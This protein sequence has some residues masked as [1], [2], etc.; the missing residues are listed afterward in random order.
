M[1]KLRFVFVGAAVFLLI[2]SAILPANAAVLKNFT[3][4]VTASNNNEFKITSDYGVNLTYDWG[5]QHLPAQRGGITTFRGIDITNLGSVGDTYDITASSSNED[6][7]CLALYRTG[8]DDAIFSDPLPITIAP[9]ETRS[10]EVRCMIKMDVVDIPTG[11]LPIVVEAH[12][13][14]DTNVGDSL[15]VYMNIIDIDDF[16][17]EFKMGKTEYT[18]KKNAP[19]IF[20]TF[21]FKNVGNEM[22]GLTGPCYTTYNDR[23]EPTLSRYCCMCW[24]DLIPNIPVSWWGMLIS[25]PGTHIVEFSGTVYAGEESYDIS[26]CNFVHIKNRSRQY[27]GGLLNHFPM[28]ERLLPLFNRLLNL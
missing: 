8:G 3:E 20:F 18:H 7:T 27:Q 26:Y 13:Q 17:V 10:F 2:L 23:G 6:I 4:N 11:K 24:W 14:N 22:I 12:S 25:I 15:T 5:V 21:S 1:K 16:P 9:G 19:I 28:L